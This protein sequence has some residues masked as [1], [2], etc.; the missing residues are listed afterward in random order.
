MLKVCQCWDDGVV[1]DE[2]L[3]GV[4]RERGA[5][6]SFNLNPGL[7]EPERKFGW[8]YKDTEVWRLGWDELEE[9]YAGFAIANHTVSHPWLDRIGLDEARREIA[10][11][12]D[13]LQQRFQ[14]PVEGFA[15]PFGAYNEDVMEAV[16]EAGHLYARTVR[17][18]DQ[19]LA[20][21]DLMAYHPSCHFLADDFWDRYEKAKANGG[22][23]YFWGHSYE[24]ISEQMWR[25]FEEKIARISGD[26]Q[27][28]WVEVTDLARESSA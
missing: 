18:V 3:A 7:H 21:E 17:N 25:D 24:L 13:R 16:R 5:R 1:A 15:Y 26:E 14:Q 20:V 19:P 12:R 28:R 23:F 22:A 8:I 6:A 2:R 11:G 4:L 10:E 27:A 9:V